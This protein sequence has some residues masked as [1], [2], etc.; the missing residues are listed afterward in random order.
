MGSMLVLLYGFY[1]NSRTH[2]ECDLLVLLMQ[3]S[4]SS[5]STHALTWSAT[6]RTM[7]D[8]AAYGIS[9][10]ALT[11]SATTTA[12]T[13]MIY[14]KISTHALTWS[15]T[16]CSVQVCRWRMRFQLTH[17]RGV[18]LPAVT[19]CSEPA[20]FNSRTHVECD[21][22]HRMTSRQHVEFQLTHSRG[23][24]RISKTVHLR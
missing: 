4:F 1:F 14:N 13:K 8:L 23:V 24:R 17:S 2:V 18:R 10:H 22:L 20:N 11:W 19:G 12:I 5:I 9:T 15:A 16:S 7:G 3:F 21:L 6:C